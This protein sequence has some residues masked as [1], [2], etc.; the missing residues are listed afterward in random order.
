[1]KTESQ[2]IKPIHPFLN[3]TVMI[4]ALGYFVD[5]YDLVL[6]SIVRIA[7]LK[8]L[9]FEGQDLTDVGLSLLNVQMA[10]LLIGGIIWGSLGDKRGRLSV[11]FGS[12]A[13]YSVA[14]L[15]NAFVTTKEMYATLRFIAGV[16]LAGELGAA[17]TLVSEI[18]PVAVR[19]Y[20]TAFIA[21][22]G[23]LGAILAALIA[24]FLDWRVAYGIGG[25]MGL[26]LLFA[27][28]KLSDS[29][30]F[31]QMRS[32]SVKR[33]NI[34]MLFQTRER[35]QRYLCT[36]AIGI[37][38]WFVLGILLAFGPEITAQMGL[39][40]SLAVGTGVMFQYSG[41]AL[42]DFASGA[43][44]QKIKS[45]NRVVFYSIIATAVLVGVFLLSRNMTPA[46]YY[47]LYFGLG[48]TTGYW[49]VFVTI[50]AEQFGTNLRATAAST[51][52]NFVR[53]AVI[54]MS[55]FIQ[56][57]KT[58]LGLL[59]AVGSVATIVMVLALFSLSRLKDS[60]A[61]NLNFIEK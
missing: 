55:V 2:V 40:G 10:G 44:S 24:D 18:L 5:V 27:R 22:I 1:M 8:D 41:A 33:G 60:Y 31:K 45:R 51:A 53:G 54:P 57:L 37:P 14:N 46:F 3:R 9:G 12:I 25:I 4:A 49:A 19:G 58:H 59:T 43:M 50:A 34:L 16:G 21:A 42:G 29:V 48:F 28:A 36:I 15:L 52:P 13:L 32:D 35:L 39:M 6:F 7:S 26:C 30:I 17:V 61:A 11:L 47:A 38:C 23:I 20:S 56:L